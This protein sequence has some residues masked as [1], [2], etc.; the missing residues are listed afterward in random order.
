M[1]SK[2]STL[3][4]VGVLLA[5]AVPSGT[6]WAATGES[7]V[8]IQTNELENKIIDF[9]RGDDGILKEVGRVATSGR[10]SGEFK[11]VTGQESA[12]NAFEGAGSVI[13]SPD[14]KHLFATNGGNNTVSVFEITANRGLKLLDTEATGQPVRGAAEPR[15][16][17]PIIPPRARSTF[18]THSDPT[19]S[20]LWISKRAI[21]PRGR[22]NIQ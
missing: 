19:I 2:K 9:R 4:G 17:W 3:L 16:R 7:H 10:G 13:I 11:P 20:E 15:N 14:R 8:Y 21:S 1:T 22:S 18:C 6:G 12:P 5:F